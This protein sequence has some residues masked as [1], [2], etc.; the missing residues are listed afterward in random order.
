MKMFYKFI[1]PILMLPF[2]NGASTC[3]AGEY[4]DGETCADCLQGIRYTQLL[5]TL[6]IIIKVFILLDVFA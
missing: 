6:S 4:L 1:L 3:P 2:T 5:H